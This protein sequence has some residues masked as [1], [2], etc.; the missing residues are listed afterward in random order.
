MTRLARNISA[1]LLSNVWS[2]ALSLLLTPVYVSYLGVES[3]GLIGFYVSW[4]AIF[5]LLDT[6]ISATAVRETAWLAARPDERNDIPSLMRS[7]EVAYWGIILTAGAALLAAVWWFGA[8]WFHTV[9]VSP[10]A[11]RTALLLMVISLVLQVPSGLYVGGLMGLQRQV[12][13]S[14]LVALFGTVRGA[15]AV[16]VLFIAPDIRAFFIWQVV[17]SALQTG[18]MRWAL[19]RSLH[20]GDRPAAFSPRLLRSVRRFAG[21]MSLVTALSLVLTQVDKMILS[22]LVSLETFGLYMLA[23]TV[24]SGLSR[25]VSPL[26]QAFN[27]HFTELVSR[28]DEEGLSRQIRIASQLTSALV[29]PP[30]ALLMVLSRQILTAWI[31]NPVTAAGAAPLLTVLAL[32]TLLLA[33][34]DPGLAVLYSRSRLGPVIKLNVAA[35]VVLLPALMWAIVRFGAIGAAFSWVAYGLAMY[36]AYQR[37]GLR[38]LRDVGTMFAVVRDFLGPALMAFIVAGLTWQLSRLADGR[39]QIAAVVALGLVVGW[40]ATLMVCSDL[41]TIA[42]NRFRWNSITT[43]WSA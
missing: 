30:A 22:R 2:T 4:I 11:V 37:I 23:W 32:G 20:A 31:G 6:A 17:A 8:R 1:N 3:Y 38:G 7:L 10:D 12:E 41:L 39:I 16:A 27:P 5:G 36:V 40:A 9:N 13:A 21:G 43:L 24:A 19:Q 25:L 34:A 42:V 18:T 28:G 33:S 29:L 35:V 15:V 26:W 14:G